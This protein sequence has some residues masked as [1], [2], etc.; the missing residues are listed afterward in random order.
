MEQT[1][2]QAFKNIGLQMHERIVRVVNDE[3]LIAFL[4]K[5][6]RSGAHALAR[7]ALAQYRQQFGCELKITERSLAC[8]IYWHYYCLDKAASFERRHGKRKF[9]SWLIRHIDISDCGEKEVDS[10]RFVWDILSIV[11]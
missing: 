6:K 7:H 2:N 5:E 3:P 11:F 9:T 1:G 10:N 4:K 8:E